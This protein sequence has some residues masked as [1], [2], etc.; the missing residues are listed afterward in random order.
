MTLTLGV[1]L[2]KSK[3]ILLSVIWA[4]ASTSVTSIGAKVISLFAQYAIFIEV[5]EI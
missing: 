4:F 5:S 1:A 3:K 2:S